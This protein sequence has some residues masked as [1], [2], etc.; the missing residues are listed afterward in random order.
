MARIRTH[1]FELPGR[2]FAELAARTVPD[3]RVR[4]L[5]QGETLTVE[6]GA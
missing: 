6:R 3:A 2:R 5:G 4:V 1:M